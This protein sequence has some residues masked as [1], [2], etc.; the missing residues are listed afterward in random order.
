MSEEQVKLK[1]IRRK[2]VKAAVDTLPVP[3]PPPP[4]PPPPLCTPATALMRY[5]DTF[6]KYR[7]LCDHALTLSLIWDTCNPNEQKDISDHL[8]GE[9]HLWLRN[10]IRL[11]RGR[12]I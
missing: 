5:R 8:R 2:K 6:Q 9:D 11:K 7:T 10:F 4:P 12:L 1:I 3:T